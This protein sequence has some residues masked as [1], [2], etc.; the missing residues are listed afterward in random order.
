MW[1][2]T[3]PPWTAGGRKTRNRQRRPD[4]SSTYTHLEKTRKCSPRG[5]PPSGGSQLQGQPSGQLANARAAPLRQRRRGVMSTASLDAG[6]RKTASKH[7]FWARTS[8][9]GS[10]M[11]TTPWQPA[12]DMVAAPLKRRSHGTVPGQFSVNLR[13]S[14]G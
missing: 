13:A 14:H 9:H 11:A 2:P 10:G 5:C 3:D 1:I 12:L 6:T 7:S 8:L 4:A